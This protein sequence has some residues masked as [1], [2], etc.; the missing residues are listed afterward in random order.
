VVHAK[1]TRAYNATD[2]R[3]IFKEAGER[4]IESK[5]SIGS[6]DNSNL[7]DELLIDSGFINNSASIGTKSSAQTVRE[8]GAKFLKNAHDGWD[9]SMA[10]VKKAKAPFF[11]FQNPGQLSR[12]ENGKPLIFVP[13]VI[14]NKWVKNI[15]DVQWHFY[16][17]EGKVIE[18]NWKP[19]TGGLFQTKE[20]VAASMAVLKKIQS[21]IDELSR[22]PKNY[23]IVEVETKYGTKKKVVQFEKDAAIAIQNTLKK[24]SIDNITNN[25]RKV[26]SFVGKKDW[27]DVKEWDEVVGKEQKN[28]QATR[29]EEQY[30]TI[31]PNIDFI[32]ELQK[33]G[34]IS[35]DNQI[36]IFLD[37]IAD[38]LTQ[39]NNNTRVNAREWLKAKHD[40]V[41]ESIKR[42]I[43]PKE[44][45][46]PELIPQLK[47]ISAALRWDEKFLKKAL[48]EENKEKYPKMSKAKAEAL[49]K[50]VV[51]KIE[52]M[53]TNA[54]EALQ[55]FKVEHPEVD[56]DNFL[57]H[58]N[59]FSDLNFRL[60][61]TANQKM[62]NNEMTHQLTLGKY[63][64][65]ENMWIKPSEIMEL[66]RAE[67]GT[68]EYE[69]TFNRIVKSHAEWSDDFTTNESKYGSYNVSM[70]LSQKMGIQEGIKPEE[71][72]SA[73]KDIESLPKEQAVQTRVAISELNPE[74]LALLDLKDPDIRRAVA[75]L[76]GLKDSQD[77]SATHQV[78]DA[79]ANKDP[80][81]VRADPSK[82]EEYERQSTEINNK[83]EEALDIVRT[84]DL[85]LRLLDIL[86]EHRDD[87]YSP[88][89]QAKMQKAMND[90]HNSLASGK[91]KDAND[92][93]FANTNARTQ[94]KEAQQ[95]MY[96]YLEKTNATGNL[97]GIAGAVQ[98]FLL[99]TY[100]SLTL[101]FSVGR[102]ITEWA[103]AWVLAVTNKIDQV[104]YSKYNRKN[105]ATLLEITEDK[106][107]NA[108]R[109]VSETSLGNREFGNETNPMQKN[110]AEKPELLKKLSYIPSKMMEVTAWGMEK[111]VGPIEQFFYETEFNRAMWEWVEKNPKERSILFKD[112]LSTEN[113][114]RRDNIIQQWKREARDS[115]KKAYFD[116]STNPL[117]INKLETYIPFTNFMYNGINM[118]QK[119]PMTFMF[120]ATVL[121]NLQYA[122]GQQA[123]YVDD[124]GQKI[125]AGMSLRLPILASL[126]LDSVALNMNRVLQV[127]PGSLGIKPAGWYNVI[128]GRDD[129]RFQKFYKSGSMMDYIDI[130]LSMM[131]PPLARV[132]NA[133]INYNQ[134]KDIEGKK[135]NALA[136]LNSA[137]AYA[138][139]GLLLTDKSTSKAWDMYINKDYEGLLN[140]SPLQLNRFLEEDS[141]VKKGVTLQTLKALQKANKIGVFGTF[142]DPFQEAMVTMGALPLHDSIGTRARLESDGKLIA[143]LTET[144]LGKNFSGAEEGNFQ[145][146]LE[147]WKQMYKDPSF[148]EFEKAVPG[149]GK[150]IRHFVENEPYYTERNKAYD[151]I[152][153]GDKDTA[154]KWELRL[155]ALQYRFVWDEDMTLNEK[156]SAIQYGKLDTPLFY[157]SSKDGIPAHSVQMTD[158]YKASLQYKGDLTYNYIQKTNGISALN[159]LR[160]A[161]VTMAYASSKTA[162]KNKYFALAKDAY[163]ES[164]KAEHEMKVMCSPE[165][166]LFQLSGDYKKFEE[167][168]KTK[169]DWKDYAKTTNWSTS[170]AKNREIYMASTAKQ[171]EANIQKLIDLS[172]SLS[173]DEK[174]FMKDALGTD[175]KANIDYFNKIRGDSSAS[176][177]IQ[178][179]KDLLDK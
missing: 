178:T 126:G 160:K 114:I 68:Q 1:P 168:T 110:M 4:K 59:K 165:Y 26:L 145:D 137:M 164:L 92:R 130:G 151:M 167:Y 162:D 171:R 67:P 101:G 71:F 139:T 32:K 82:T 143:N 39:F 40:Q 111:T 119:Y 155:I 150:A 57:I 99:K 109:I 94:L 179:L 49:K 74:H 80:L 47:N 87:P 85:S 146:T 81:L 138:T 8:L 112:N 66:K 129:P 23:K 176:S 42:D 77:I 25:F 158:E 52:T 153:S 159:S 97:P 106:L 5:L 70:P 177:G 103:Q 60:L 54:K 24:Y 174:T 56:T 12:G 152:K 11:S 163:N 128:T 33:D 50:Q 127:S 36:S 72:T 27:V 35:G 76:I 16:D 104:M 122:Y 98:D 34:I 61:N 120:G 69:D 105:I 124:E 46:A 141:I 89:A 91:L 79:K 38:K 175:V 135:Y 62:I 84:T 48:V 88:V 125:D 118:M 58:D 14:A 144:V 45:V 132:V 10:A 41:F 19:S 115:T 172:N 18:K 107:P 102:G 37:K 7:I 28:R 169:T 161:F 136:E 22:D 13:E 93:V 170:F 134:T 156:V 30:N 142:D 131:S 157:G 44:N 154:L 148:K 29:F 31:R 15:G 149:M 51:A 83:K 95:A 123:L 17:K 100:K 3:G 96:D 53:I 108:G 73:L 21:K 75:F 140:M 173:T 86:K 20:G 147:K 90:F 6:I 121:N 2:Y 116:Y 166:A 65:L 133:I 117:I 43:I 55:T 64:E 78:I 9:V 113:R 63:D